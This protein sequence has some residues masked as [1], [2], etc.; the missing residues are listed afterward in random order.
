MNVLEKIL[1]ETSEEIRGSLPQRADGLIKARAIIRSHMNHSGDDT[2]MGDW[3]P[4]S[5]RLPEKDI[6]VLVSFDDGD[7]VIAWYSCENNT[8]VWRN[9]STNIVIQIDVLAWQPLPEPYK[10]KKNIPAAGMDHIMSRF[11]KVE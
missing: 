7:E 8:D 1:E 10:P 4:C 9:S 3:I 5:K 6:D 11:T 2:E